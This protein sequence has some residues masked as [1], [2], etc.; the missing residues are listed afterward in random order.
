MDHLDLKGSDSEIDL[1]SGG[2]V[3]DDDGGEHLDLSGRNSK[4]GLHMVWSELVGQESADA[5]AKGEK[6]AHSLGK[7]LSYDEILVK[8]ADRWP[9][10]FEEEFTNFSKEKRAVEKPKM[11]NSKRPP[12]PPRPPGGPSLDSAD[13]KLIKEI[14]ELAILKRKRTERRKAL[15]KMRK[16][17]TYSKSSSLFAMVVTALFIFV[18]IFQGSGIAMRK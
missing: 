9:E 18:I 15:Q 2:N 10:K 17:K 14:S 5:S 8:N 6:S 16:E 4:K 13:M 1:E 3:T 12:K 7:L 11:P